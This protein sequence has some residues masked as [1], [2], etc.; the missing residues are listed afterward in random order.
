MVPFDLAESILN[1]VLYPNPLILLS[2]NRMAYDP[3]TANRIR[4]IMKRKRGH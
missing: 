3:T 2:R 1:N 4:K